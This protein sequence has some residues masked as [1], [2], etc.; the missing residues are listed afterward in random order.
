MSP[1]LWPLRYWD[2]S[3][4]LKFFAIRS[5]M[6]DFWLYVIA[7][8]SLWKIKAEEE[9]SEE[10]PKLK[11]MYGKF[12]GTR[13]MI[14]TIVYLVAIVLA[15][16]LPAYT[17]NVYIVRWLPLWMMFSASFM[18]AWILQLPLQL[19]WRMKDLS[20]WLIF[21]RIS[22]LIILIVTV[23][24]LL[25]HVS[26]SNWEPKSIIAFVLILFSVLASGITQLIYVLYKS[27][28]K[29]KLKVDFD[30][31]F[32]KWIIKWNRKYWLSYYLSS[33]HT[34]IVLIFLSNFFP[35]SEWFVYTGIR[36]LWLTLMEIFLIIPSAL[37]NSLLHNVAWYTK[38][39]KA[40]SFGNLMTMVVWIW[41]IIL[42][43]FVLFSKEII[44]TI[45]WMD[46]IWTWLH[47]PWANTILP[48][49]WLVLFLSFIKQI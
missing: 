1:Y 4:I 33:F 9:N 15:Y 38:E 6:A 48:F 24:V 3:T 25:P 30:K 12:V 7:V 43:N 10:K 46:F 11:A 19:F 20:M 42:I 37:W 14:M 49:L 26:F 5:A 29:L 32:T 35:T 44:Y 13:F 36:W 18:A 39:N 2:Y 22:Q 21:A 47:N 40:K 16:F 8:K 34:L 23:F 28:Q 45:S 27:N 17:S 31:S 41:S